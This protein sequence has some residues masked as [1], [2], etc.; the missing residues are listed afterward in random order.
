MS[1][2]IEDYQK[3]VEQ[4]DKDH[5]EAMRHAKEI[6]QRAITTNEQYIELFLSAG[7]KLICDCCDRMLNHGETAFL[8]CMSLRHGVQ[9][10]HCK[11]CYDNS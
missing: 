2:P 11:S 10:V 9:Y 7:E 3:N 6:Y 4:A 5:D 1:T 8:L